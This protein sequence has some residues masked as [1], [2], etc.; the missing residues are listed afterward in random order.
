[1]NTNA[2]E[3][4]INALEI[5]NNLAANLGPAFFDYVELVANLLNSQLLTYSYSRAIRKLAV[6]TIKNLL[7]ACSDS[8]QMKALFNLLYPTLKTTIEEKLTKTDFADLRY[9]LK[10]L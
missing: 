6:K 9:L 5:I 7:M 10:E 3:S 2:L 8:N 1:M 4:K